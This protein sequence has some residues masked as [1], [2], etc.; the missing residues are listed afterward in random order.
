VAKSR[1]KTVDEYIARAPVGSRAMLRELRAILR[2]AAPRATEAIKWGSPV[3]VQGRIL[4]SYSAYQSHLNFMPTRPALEPFKD[5][6]SGFKTGKDT[7]QF[8][9]GQPLP[10]ALI[11]RIAAFRLKQV[12]DHDARWMY[13]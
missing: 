1:A 2:R 7:V 5:A 4:F 8:P 3:L 9:Y 10:K 13:R 12:K 11:R 6:L